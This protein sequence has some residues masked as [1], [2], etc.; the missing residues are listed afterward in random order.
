MDSSENH[1]IKFLLHILRYNFIESFPHFRFFKRNVLKREKNQP[2]FK[3]YAQKPLNSKLYFTKFCLKCFHIF[4][5]WPKML[6]QNFCYT[7]IRSCCV[8]L[9]VNIA[10]VDLHIYFLLCVCAFIHNTLISLYFWTCHKEKP[11]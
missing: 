9:L 5:S 6:Q 11:F 7:S 4:T 8:S 3:A 10:V 1:L 2:F